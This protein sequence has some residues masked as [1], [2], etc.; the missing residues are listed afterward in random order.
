MSSSYQDSQCHTNMK[1]AATRALVEIYKPFQEIHRSMR[2]MPWKLTQPDKHDR[3]HEKKPQQGKEQKAHRGFQAW[4][5]DLAQ[6]GAAGEKES[7]TS[8]TGWAKSGTHGKE[9]LRP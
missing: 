3:R 1:K 7:S 2:V 9:L 6:G 4:A 5:G 8:L